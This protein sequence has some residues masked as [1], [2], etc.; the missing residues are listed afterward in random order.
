MDKSKFVLMLR[1]LSF[2][3]ITLGVLSAC[4]SNPDNLV[5]E[6]G[7]AEKI[8][9]GLWR[10]ELDL[11]TDDSVNL[12]FEFKLDSVNDQLEMTLINGAEEISGHIVQVNG[13]SI[14]VELAVFNG[15]L[16][17]TRK[18]NRMDG[19]FHNLAKGPEYK[20]PLHCEFGLNYR[21][22]TTFYGKKYDFSGKW[23]TIFNEG[24][25]AYPAIG[26]FSQIG[27]KITGT[28]LT[29]T[30]DFRFLEG[31]VVDST[32]VLTA[33][34]GSH[35]FYFR[36]TLSGDTIKG[37]FNSGSH[38][39]TTWKAVRNENF[40]LS[41]PYKLTYLKEGYKTI[42]FKFPGL[43]SDT[44]S[45]QDEKYQDRVVLIQ[46][47]GSWCP[48]CMDECAYFEELYTKYHDR[49]L[50]IIGIAFEATKDLEQARKDLSKLVDYYELPYDFGIGGF[51]SKK[52][53]SEAFPMLNKI[54]SYPTSILLDKK[55]NVVQ[56]HTGFSGPSTGDVFE[57]Y[58]KRMEASIE[59][60]L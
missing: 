8:P 18:G 60:V 17:L 30:G 33:F 51:A 11:M 50:E 57:T 21:V 2:S 13:D 39:S 53:A 40:H 9:V 28:F 5:T 3:V 46:I 16:V 38:Y 27:D 22:G 4:T 58:K 54:M 32:M 56:I 14:T 24:E 49:G 23:E 31:Q 20:L 59:K 52:V 19:Y 41:D 12:P 1:R 26:S 48:N 6:N 10:G 36:G 45:L 34:D 44:I 42:D 47:M 25:D 55:G 35:A 15:V 43:K 37:V 7:V 29:E